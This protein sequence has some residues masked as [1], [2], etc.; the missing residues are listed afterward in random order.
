MNE[1]GDLMQIRRMDPVPGKPRVGDAV[2]HHTILA[3][4]KIEQTQMTVAKGAIPR[5]V[6]SPESDGTTR[7]D[8]SPNDQTQRNVKLK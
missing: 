2:S 1:A 3:D 6:V 8:L 4:F 5:P 7:V